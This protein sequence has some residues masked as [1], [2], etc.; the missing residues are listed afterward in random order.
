MSLE[1]G[2]IRWLWSLPQEYLS[3]SVKAK[4]LKSE[5]DGKEFAGVSRAG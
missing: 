3:E 1:K 5:N 4:L 2:E